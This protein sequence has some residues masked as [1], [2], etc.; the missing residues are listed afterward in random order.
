[1][2]QRKRF[3]AALLA[4]CLAL[5]VPAGASGTDHVSRHETMS[6]ERLAYLS[7]DGQLM[8]WEG[9]PYDRPPGENT[10]TP[11][12]F[13]AVMEGVVSFTAEE[14]YMVLK[15]DGTL[16][17]WGSNDRGRMGIGVFPEGTEGY[18]YYAPQKVMDNV[19][20]VSSFHAVTAAIKTDGSLWMWGDN[21]LGQLGN[22]TLTDSAAPV[23]VM[24]GVVSVSV[25]A[26]MTAAVKA[27]GT[28]WTW[29]ANHYGHLGNGGVTNAVGR[30]NWDCLTV[31][32]QVMEDV[33]SVSVGG[34]F[35]AAVK[36][37]G[38]L[39]TWGLS[40]D[41]HLG[42]GDEGN[43][44]VLG[45]RLQNVPKQIMEG[46]ASVSCGSYHT[47]AVKKDGSLWGWGSNR[48]GELGNGGAGNDPHAL[49]DGSET[50]NHQ[51]VPAR[52]M[53]GV[54]AV[55]C[56]ENRSL[57]LK[58]DGTLWVCG[59]IPAGMAGVSGYQVKQ[60]TPLQIASGVALPARLSP[61]VAGFADVYEDD[62]YAQAVAWAKER[63]VTGGTSA[64]TFSPASPVTRAEA[65]TFLW[66]GAGSPEPSS[67]ASPFADVADPAAY[68]YKAVLWAWEEGITGGVSETSFGLG[69]T[70]SYDQL[71]AFLAR[72]A[73]A[74]TGGGDWSRAALTWAAEQ[75]LTAGLTFEAKDPCPRSDVV[76]CLW[77]QLA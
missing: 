24:D 23:K 21:R 74:D 67:T 53:D 22:G 46:V 59:Q 1:M 63:G 45:R 3:A 49:R 27:D 36:T 76:Y 35:C 69:S 72:A 70:L 33:L 71:L 12:Q 48:Y 50:W 42:D 8:M 17:S 61:T 15:A 5:A 16:W 66:R 11:N 9:N 68:Y 32:T 19:A 41:G 20:A 57:L 73:G 37:D 60:L 10:P 52:I 51:T 18:Y 54:A 39:W 7:A 40:E 56:C 62:Y 65:V 31:P 26:W 34:N 38:T 77:R 47:L 30:Y 4:L 28:L 58:T 43:V 55:D 13:A 25:G 29:G 75:G 14:H 6:A 2:R 64:T 44:T